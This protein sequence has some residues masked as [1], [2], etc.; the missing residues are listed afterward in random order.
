LADTST[1]K[2]WV[3][4]VD[5]QLAQIKAGF[6]RGGPYVMTHSDLHDENI[7]V[8]EN[9]DGKWSVSAIIDWEHS[10]FAPWW[11]EAMTM[12]WGD[13]EFGELAQWRAYAH[14]GHSVEEFEKVMKQIDPTIKAFQS[15]T[16]LAVNKHVPDATNRWYTP[17]FCRCKPFVGYIADRELGV[18][19]SR[20]LDVFDPDLTNAD[21]WPDEQRI[22]SGD[23]DSELEFMRL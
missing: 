16:S 20:H 8:A 18:E 22:L 4:D 6:P 13:E 2:F 10:G 9:E 7:F 5:K 1:M 23:H 12:S 15:G 14:P 3:A 21:D 17:P 19:E 11:V